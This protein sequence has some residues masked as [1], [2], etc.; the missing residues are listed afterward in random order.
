MNICQFPEQHV[1]CKNQPFSRKLLNGLLE[2][3]FETSAPITGYLRIA[4]SAASQFF[5]FFYNGVPYAAGSYVNGK[6]VGFTIGELGKH[7]QAA[8]VSRMTVTFS[9]TD[10]VLFKNMLLVLHKKPF[11]KAPADHVDL[12]VIVRQFGE[13]KVNA[14]IALCR[15]TA[16]NFFF[17]RDGNAVLAHYADR[18]FERPEGLTLEEEL[19]AYAYQPGSQVEACVF[20]DMVTAE[21]GDAR[22][23]DRDM[24][25]TLL[26]GGKTI[27]GDAGIAPSLGTDPLMTLR[28][29]PDQMSFTLRVESG[30]QQGETHTV[31]PP[32]LIGRK[33]CDLVLDDNQVSRRH[34]EL[35]IVEQKLVI[36]DLM[37]T[38]GTQVN[39]TM[40]TIQQL[41]PNDLITI[42]DTSL[43]ILPA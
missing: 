7:L 24:L 21:A 23:Y 22:R 28:Q 5:L 18:D 30:P 29:Q 31:R 42:G 12:A 41:A 9:E 27:Q 34:A 19:H 39:G 37:S 25:L 20:R 1:L 8:D 43:R 36:E 16:C 38:N 2:K 10:P 40:I 3:V 11:I 17:F 32:C 13:G 4:D 14:M 33:D 35:K 26:C 15:N 6:P